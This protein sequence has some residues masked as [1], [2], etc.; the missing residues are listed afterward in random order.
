M[1]RSFQSIPSAT[2]RYASGSMT[3]TRPGSFPGRFSGS[4]RIWMI[5]PPRA[6]IATNRVRVSS[7][8]AILASAL[9]L[10]E[11]RLRSF[12]WFVRRIHLLEGKVMNF[13][14]FPVT[15]DVFL[16][17]I[18]I[19]TMAQNSTT[20]DAAAS[21]TST[22]NQGRAPPEKRDQAQPQG[23]T[24]A[25]NTTSGGAP[26]SSQGETPPGMQPAPESSSQGTSGAR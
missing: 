8:A 16:A 4:S 19:A 21:Q 2:M 9:E 23:S 5:L 20:P 10:D 22:G 13:R 14:N 26:A 3:C 25:L 18:S 15:A 7:W 12:K 17:G 6:S 11:V 1:L 24:G